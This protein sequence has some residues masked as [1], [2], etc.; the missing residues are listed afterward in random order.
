MRVAVP[1]AWVRA[2]RTILSADTVSF[3]AAAVLYY[4]ATDDVKGFA[5]TLGLSTILDLVVVFLFTHP[6]VSLLSR[7]A[8]VRLGRASPAWTRCAAGTSLTATP[9]AAARP[10]AVDGRR[11]AARSRRRRCLRP[12]DERRATPD[13]AAGDADRSP[14]SRRVGTRGR[15][16]TDGRAAAPTTA[17]AG[18]G[19]RTRCRAAR[20]DAR[21]ATAT[22]RARADV[23]RI[24]RLYRGETN[25]QFIAHAQAVVPRLGRCMI[26]D[27]HRSAS[28]FRGFNF[29]IE[30]TGGTQFQFP[31]TA[32]PITDGA[33]RHRVRRR[34]A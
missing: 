7:V 27:L 1:R 14:T 34:R 6:L 3:L 5:F 26:A 12:R 31:A 18:L 10:A 30:F 20:P 11:T 33:G 24:R 16:A 17:R 22:R 13:A 29:G 15:S 2:R 19:R 9:T 28:S 8:H 23:R 21:A 4:F 32:G 25:I